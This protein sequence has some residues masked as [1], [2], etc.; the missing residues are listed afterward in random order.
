MTLAF[1]EFDYSLSREDTQNLTVGIR[2]SGSAIASTLI[3]RVYPLN[4]T[5]VNQARES[6]DPAFFIEGERVELPDN[7]VIPENDPI[8]P[9][10]ATSM[11][12]QYCKIVVL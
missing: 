4:N 8:R 6:T 3:V 9:T 11:S 10:V 1:T 7:F 5:F 2:R 12:D